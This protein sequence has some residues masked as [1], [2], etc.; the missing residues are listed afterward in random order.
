MVAKIEQ[1]LPAVSQ[2]QQRQCALMEQ[3]MA[4]FHWL[5]APGAA[6]GADAFGRG[7]GAP[8]WDAL[9]ADVRGDARRS[10]PEARR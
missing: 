2:A 8:W 6:C 10:H 3:V 7:G 5:R 9:L 4:E 1:N